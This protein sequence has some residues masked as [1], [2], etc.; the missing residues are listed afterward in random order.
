MDLFSDTEDVN[1]DVNPEQ[2]GGG[3][4]LCLSIKTTP[5]AKQLDDKDMKKIASARLELAHSLP[6]SFVE[7]GT[8]LGGPEGRGWGGVDKS[9]IVDC[10]IVDAD[11][12]LHD[13]LQASHGWEDVNPEQLAILASDSYNPS[14]SGSSQSPTLSGTPTPRGPVHFMLGQQGLSLAGSTTPKEFGSAS[15]AADDKAHGLN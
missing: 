7:G 8:Y 3:Y 13:G 11:H 4:D 9:Q 12:P 2:T 15:G 1:M 10:P 6:I 5:K 14:Q